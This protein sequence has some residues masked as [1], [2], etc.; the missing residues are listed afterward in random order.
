MPVRSLPWSKF[1]VPVGEA[2]TLPSLVAHFGESWPMVAPYFRPTSRLAAA[3]DCPKPGGDGC[4]RRVVEHGFDDLVA[5]CGN[6]PQEC[7]TIPVSR[8]DVLIHELRIDSLLSDLCRLLEVQGTGP[9]KILSLTWNM[10]R[11]V[12]PGRQ[13]LPVWLCLESEVCWLQQ[14]VMTLPDRQEVPALLMIASLQLCPPSLLLILQK[15]RVGL[16]PLDTLATDKDGSD[17]ALFLAHYATDGRG[18]EATNSGYV[19]RRISDYWQIMFRGKSYSFKH[20]EGIG[21]IAQLLRRAY[22]DEDKIQASE[23]FYLVHGYQSVQKTA[24]TRLST[25]EL[26]E[27][28]LEVTGLGDGLDIISPE[29]KQWIRAQREQLS[30]QM[31]EATEC[32]DVEEASRCRRQKEELEEYLAKACGL[33]GRDRKVGDPVEKVRQLVS[34]NINN[35]LAGMKKKGAKDLADYLRGRCKLGV[36]CSFVKDDA[37]DW[38]VTV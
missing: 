16:V 10:G 26:A 30:Q 28:G 18:K 17:P 29:G 20:S 21:Y 31:E 15:Q 6:S 35:A 2:G 32:G 19:L 27:I 22:D 9:E 1:G 4:P 12:R 3:I 13:S 25:V 36:Q 33:M 7:P 5:V 24:L 14:A 37:C 23:L 8:Q 34:K 38:Q 11:Y